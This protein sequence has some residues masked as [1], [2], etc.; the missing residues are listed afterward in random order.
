MDEGCRQHLLALAA[1]HKKS[2]S[3]RKRLADLAIEPQTN[4][5]RRGVLDRCEFGGQFRAADRKQ[6]RSAVRGHGQNNRIE[7]VRL[8]AR[9]DHPSARFRLNGLHQRTSQQ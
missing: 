1:R 9:R 5:N 3:R 4:G 6:P 2:E 8:Q 7:V